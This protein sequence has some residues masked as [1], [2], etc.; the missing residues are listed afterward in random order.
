MEPD[1]L[2]DHMKHPW[3]CIPVTFDINANLL[4]SPV[5]DVTYLKQHLVLLMWINVNRTENTDIIITYDIHQD[6]NSHFQRWNAASLT[7]LAIKPLSLCSLLIAM[8]GSTNLQ[9]LFCN[10]GWTQLQTAAWGLCQRVAQMN[11]SFPFSIRHDTVSDAF[12]NSSLGQA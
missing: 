12:G 9:E 5:E 10:D 3:Q 1:S 8:K 11:F 4:L 6:K 7:Y 2:V